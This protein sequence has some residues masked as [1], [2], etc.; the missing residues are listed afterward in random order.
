MFETLN[1]DYF[2]LY[3]CISV[4]IQFYGQKNLY[5]TPFDLALIFPLD[6]ARLQQSGDL[7][8]GNG[9]VRDHYLN[10]LPHGVRRNN[11][12]VSPPSAAEIHEDFPRKKKEINIVLKDYLLNTKLCSFT[13]K[14]T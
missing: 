11:P 4:F 12:G 2:I 1:L 6:G 9:R 13:L 7:S 8:K 10:S 5:S 3:V 14:Y